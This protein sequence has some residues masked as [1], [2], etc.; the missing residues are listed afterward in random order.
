MARSVKTVV[1]FP[2][3]AIE[4]EVSR[5]LQSK[6]INRTVV[7]AL[8]IAI[9]V[10]QWTKSSAAESIQILFRNKRPW[11]K[12]IVE[13]VLQQLPDRVP[14]QQL[15]RILSKNR[16]LNQVIKRENIKSLKVD[17]LLGGKSVAALDWRLPKIENTA[18]LAS[19]FGISLQHLEWLTG[20]Q[21]R[22]SRH[23]QH[24]VSTWIR[25]RHDGYRLIESPKPMLKNVQRFIVQ[26]IL[27]LIPPHDAAHGFRS[28]RDVTTFVE[29]HVNK[30]FCLRM[31]LK[32]FFPSVTGGRVFGIFLRAGYPREVASALGN[33]CTTQ[34]PQTI[35][36]LQ[37]PPGQTGAHRTSQLYIPSHLP[38]GAPTSPALA[39]LAAFHFDCRLSK[40]AESRNI[41][42]SR[43][44][45][46]L[47]FSGDQE[48]A[49]SAKKFSIF[50]GAIAI[51]EGFEVNFRKSR[52]QY[53]S[54]RQSATGVVIN[55]LK[56]L[57][58]REFDRLKATLH[59]C[60]KF[61]PVS[62]NRKNHARFRQHLSGKINWVHRLNPDKARRLVRL[63]EQIEWP[64]D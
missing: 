39:N 54:Q 28:G 15:T 9:S 52:F 47:L 49:K 17:R 4:R 58:R 33:L 24:Y 20:K 62:Q 59:N 25:K 48:F 63:F 50:V 27:N 3:C 22:P 21:K 23:P 57:Q 40:L 51:E 7:E 10:S 34:T 64:N 31:D 46:D 53:S 19:Q 42:Y 36:D 61:G 38:Q 12:P 13:E 32:D 43:Y 55:Q 8:A 6:P 29:A 16:K 44:A 11:I 41:S 26:D 60:V 14:L 1:A 56:N 5:T 45:D 35:V 2:D 30:P 37:R 18:Q